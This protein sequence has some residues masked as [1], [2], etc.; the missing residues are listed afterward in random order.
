MRL[1]NILLITF[2]L[3]TPAFVNSPV[4]K[5]GESYYVT[6][7]KH[8]KEVENYRDTMYYCGAKAPTIFWGLVIDPAKKEYYESL[9]KKKQQELFQKEFLNRYDYIK[10]KYKYVNKQNELLA[11]TLLYWNVGSFGKDFNKAL[12]SG[13]INEISKQWM[14]YVYYT[15]KDKKGRKL[16]KKKSSHLIMR[17]E[18]ELKLFKGLV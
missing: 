7:I 13:D 9:S 18:F 1:I 14:R 6:A 16:K 17:R 2:I 15:P 10:D 8:L 5:Q 4:K 12:K 3:F 11:L